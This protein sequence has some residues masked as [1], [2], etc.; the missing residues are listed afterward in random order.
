MVLKK[1]VDEG[2]HRPGWTISHQMR[3][4]DGVRHLFFS[5][6]VAAAAAAAA[7]HSSLLSLVFSA[8]L[9]HIASSSLGK[10]GSEW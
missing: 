7:T 4:V 2:Y 9:C 8:A 6:C 10:D 1:G 5:P 3:G